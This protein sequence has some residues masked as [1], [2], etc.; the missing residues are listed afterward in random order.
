MYIQIWESLIDIVW[1]CCNFT[2]SS[3]GE[4]SARSPRN[5]EF[6]L[7]KAGRDASGSFSNIPKPADFSRSPS[8]R[9][10]L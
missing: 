1:R 6:C 4:K 5:W 8:S 3:S 2:F 9:I 10:N 7:S